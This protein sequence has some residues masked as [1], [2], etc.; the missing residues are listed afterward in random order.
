MARLYASKELVQALID[1]GF[2]S[3]IVK[4]KTEYVISDSLMVFEEKFITPAGLSKKLNISLGLL[5]NVF[6]I[7]QVPTLQL[8]INGG[9]AIEEI[10]DRGFELKIKIHLNHLV[11]R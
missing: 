10:I 4:N 6:K 11:S 8:P 2:L 5:E 3:Y 9:S 7:L 1:L